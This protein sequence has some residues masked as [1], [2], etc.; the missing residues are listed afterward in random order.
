MY[1]YIYIFFLRETRFPC[2]CTKL[3][4]PI[5]SY[6]QILQQTLIEPCKCKSYI[7]MLSKV[8]EISM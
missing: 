8:H 5:D 7:Q 2:Q 4:S 1:T 3:I 6:K